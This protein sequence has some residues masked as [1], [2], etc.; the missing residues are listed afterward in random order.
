M[1]NPGRP[2]IALAGFGREENYVGY[3]TDR[4]TIIVKVR[5]DAT[6]N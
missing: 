1:A 6:L 5:L 2:H 4:G 3:R